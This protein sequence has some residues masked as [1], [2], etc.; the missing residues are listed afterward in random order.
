MAGN[1]AEWC[2]DYW[3]LNYQGLPNP[4]DNPTGPETGSKR[5]LR[6]GHWSS[7]STECLCAFRSGV[8]P[9]N[10][11]SYIGFRIARSAN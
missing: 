5:L 8:N 11:T 10:A 7:N 4:D 6:G 3:N 1:I 2:N 9:S